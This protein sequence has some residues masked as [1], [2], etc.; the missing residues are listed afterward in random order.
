MNKLNLSPTF[1][2]QVGIYLP[3]PLT[4]HGKIYVA[5]SR[6][7]SPNDVKLLIIDDPNGLQG[8]Q[9]DTGRWFTKNHVIRQLWDFDTAIL[10]PIPK[11]QRP[12][13]P[14]AH[15]ESSVTQTRA[16]ITNS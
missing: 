6:V 13:P 8:R 7:Q 3:Q 9:K 12:D 10:P 4:D 14:T 11:D 16:N 1:L 5:M 2:F 15:I